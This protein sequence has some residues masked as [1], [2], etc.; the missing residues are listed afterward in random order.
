MKN[1]ASAVI[2]DLDG[3]LANSDHRLHY[4]VSD[5]SNPDWK[6]FNAATLEDKVIDSGMLLI[7]ALNRATFAVHFICTARPECVRELTQ[8]W[9]RMH[10]IPYHHLLMRKDGDARPGH[11]VKL[12]MLRQILAMGYEVAMA[13]EDHPDIIEMY[14]MSGVPCYGADP[15]HWIEGKV[16]QIAIE[17]KKAA[18]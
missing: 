16:Q 11:L 17:H 10:S 13:F 1:K 14:R 5:R 18:K 2:W 12:E 6:S 7:R 4:I 8:K 3:V 9:L 15:R